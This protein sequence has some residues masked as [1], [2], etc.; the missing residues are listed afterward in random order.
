MPEV[1][2]DGTVKKVVRIGSTVV[3][4]KGKEATMVALTATALTPGEL[5]VYRY[6]TVVI[7]RQNMSMCN[8]QCKL[9]LLW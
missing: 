2:L 3:A 7:S 8:W 9:S 5:L 1:E 4:Q 6:C